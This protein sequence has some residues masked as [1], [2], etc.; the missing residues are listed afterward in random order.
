MRF[1]VAASASEWFNRSLDREG[2]DCSQ[3]RPP[4]P[5]HSPVHLKINV[6]CG[7]SFTAIDWL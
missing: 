5:A 1:D 7:G 6:L 2:L 3:L 4:A